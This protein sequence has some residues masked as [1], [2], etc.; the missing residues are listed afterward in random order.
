MVNNNKNSI[1]AILRWKAFDE[2]YGDI[3]LCLEWE[4]Q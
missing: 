1:F 3:I 4:L 2:V